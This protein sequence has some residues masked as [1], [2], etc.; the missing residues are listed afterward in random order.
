MPRVLED[1]SKSHGLIQAPNG[2][3]DGRDRWTG[4]E[5]RPDPCLRKST[6]EYTGY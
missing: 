5:R 3:L 4:C 2:D 1:P 6:R